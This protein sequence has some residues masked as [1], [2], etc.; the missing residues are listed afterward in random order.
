LAL[1]RI[2]TDTVACLPPDLAKKYNIKVIPAAHIIFQGKSY[3]ENVN[4]SAKEAYDLI[5]KDPD[6]FI[7]SAIT[8]V[9]VLEAY[10][11]LGKDSREII[12]ITISSCLSA[13]YKSAAQAAALFK[14]ESPTTYIKI[15][16]SKSVAGGEGLLAIAAA[17]AA[18][19]G[20]NI[21][22]ITEMIEKLQKQTKLVMM[23]DTLRY[24]Y[25]SGRMS[26]LSA[27][28]VSMLNVR[29]INWMTPDG[30]IEMASRVRNRDDGIKRIVSMIKA[31]VK[32]EELIFML[33]HADDPDFI[34][35]MADSIRQNFKVK[36]LIIGD[37]SPVMGYGAGPGAICIGFRPDLKL[38]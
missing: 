17:Q 23:L 8:P 30:T 1:A 4:I 21:S 15:I 34:G 38:F 33:S 20:M 6:N 5:R 18:E 12:F 10:R 22:Q 36:D 32:D 11:E 27:R 19:K 25:R 2:M 31:E 28:L 16:D 14:E 37:Y 24:I 3:T 29:P 7:T 9:H 26:K 35:K 13:V